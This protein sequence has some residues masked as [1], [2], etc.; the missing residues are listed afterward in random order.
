VIRISTCCE[1]Q[2]VAV[3]FQDTGV[4]FNPEKRMEYDQDM[5]Q[6]SI[7]LVDDE[8]AILKVLSRDLREENFL[9]T[10]VSSGSEAIRALQKTLYDL[11]ITDLAMAEING[12]DILKA[13]RKFAPTTAVIIITGYEDSKNAREAMS[14]GVDDLLAK[15]FEVEEL[16]SSIQ[17][18]LNKRILH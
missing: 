18:C 5:I 9:V 14:I 7:L 1:N 8:L 13:T 15:P 3:T 17:A 4:D 11:V 6:P 2:S 12:V 16:L 10:A